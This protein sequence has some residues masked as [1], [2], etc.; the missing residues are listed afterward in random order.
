VSLVAR[1][2][3]TL[4]ELESMLPQWQ[5]LA[6][7]CEPTACD[8]LW[9][10]CAARHIHPPRDRLHVVTLWRDEVL[11]AVAPIMAANDRGVVRFELIGARVLYE[12]AILFARDAAAMDSLAG[13]LCRLNRPLTLTRLAHAE[14][15]EMAF[16][17]RTRRR[18]LC[19][20]PRASG[21]HWIDSAAGWDT[22]E[23]GLSSRL[24]EMVARGAK[25][26]RKLGQ[27]EFR[28]ERPGALEASE[29]LRKA[30]EV[31]LRSWKREAGSAI[32]LR[33]DLQAFFLGYG[34]ELARR[35]ELAVTFLSCNG[36][37]IAMQV[38]RI[39]GNRYW[40]LKIGFDEEFARYR[41]GWQVLWASIQACCTQGIGRYEFLGT[42]EGWLRDWSE[43]VHRYSTTVFYPF[44]PMGLV[45]LMR[46][47]SHHIFE[48]CRRYLSRS[49]RA[50]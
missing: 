39:S 44:K 7:A 26:L 32:L 17:A 19:F 5:E 42:Q 49:S 20:A 2:L 27:V 22:F 12:P 41:A 36:R 34:T 4:P 31:E 47:S 25:Q 30:F 38:A 35:N 46:D 37:D 43:S 48:K 33:P 13:E 50:P 14:P 21:S 10:L 6:A 29:V 23:A 16:R 9:Y 28:M 40:L 15:F 11:V 8:P 24:R 1:I 3:R 18:G 45:A